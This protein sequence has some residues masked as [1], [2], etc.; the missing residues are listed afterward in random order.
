MR[1]DHLENRPSLR[2][3]IVG[4]GHAGRDIHMP[5]LRAAGFSKIAIVSR[6]RRAA[7]E[8]DRSGVEVYGALDAV[9]GT[10][11]IAVIAVPDAQH[12]SIAIESLLC[13]P[14][15]LVVDKPLA[16]SSEGAERIVDAAS[17]LGVTV[18]PF[19]NR[20]WDGDYLTLE[21]LLRRGRLGKIVRLESRISMWAP[22]LS[23]GWRDVSHPGL[24]GQ[25]G[26]NGPHLVDQAVRLLGPVRN[27]Y[28]EVRTLRS[29]AGPNDDCFIALTH[30]NGASSHLIMTS[31]SGFT[32]ER[33]VAIGTAG[34]Y[35][36]EGMD[37]Q[38]SRL[39]EG[40]AHVGPATQRGYI[41]GASRR[42]VP[43][44][45][46]DWADFYREVRRAILTGSKM[47]VTASESI[48]VLRHLEQATESSR[49]RLAAAG[50]MTT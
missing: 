4:F 41:H 26:G 32:G 33:F 9:P 21:D 14:R 20:R 27:V 43:T 13:R 42:S 18:V 10:V 7:Q 30:E 2:A 24:N 5:L 40:R 44:R 28:A 39:R 45:V 23:S 49:F 47:P 38:Q 19:Q 50:P 12:E 8:A 46:G 22:E 48:E 15:V 36:V 17:C 1:P 35:T 29:D 34:T 3:L 16:T 6:G 31:L 11:D 25:L 37:P